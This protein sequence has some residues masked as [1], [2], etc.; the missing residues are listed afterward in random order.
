[1]GKVVA[2]LQKKGGAGKTTTCINLL[3]ALKEAGF[4]VILCDVDKDKPD[5]LFWASKGDELINDVIPLYDF[6]PRPKV[7]ELRKQYD[8]VILDTP[9]NFEAGTLKAASLCDFA[10]I[11]CAPSE[12]D[13][14]TLKDAMECALIIDKPY[15]FLA[16]RIDVI[17]Q[18]SKK[19]LK[20]LAE[21]GTAFE[22]YITKSVAMTGCIS[23]GQWVGSYAPNSQNHLQYQFLV[24]ELLQ[25]L[26]VEA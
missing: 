25:K 10:I 2:K 21:T 5:S 3:G 6:N 14:N 7:A 15:A 9:G 13:Q 18:D 11:P 22:T 8:F 26:G 16:N 1:M 23:K 19:L 4:R 12:L 24:N 17:T 20:E